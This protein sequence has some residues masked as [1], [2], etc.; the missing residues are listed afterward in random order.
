MGAIG[1]YTIRIC[2]LVLIQSEYICTCLQ[3]RT[4]I[5]EKLLNN[6]LMVG[7]ALFSQKILINHTFLV[8]GTV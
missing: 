8:R 1:I 4:L 5:Y 6:A 7:F 3:A 2:I